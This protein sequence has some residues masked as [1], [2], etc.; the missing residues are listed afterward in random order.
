MSAHA[1]SPSNDQEKDSELGNIISLMSCFCVQKE[2]LI[3]FA[4]SKVQ[5]CL[6]QSRHESIKDF[7]TPTIQDKPIHENTCIPCGEQRNL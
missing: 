2:V 4:F 5:M 1:V 6:N 7:Q 3:I